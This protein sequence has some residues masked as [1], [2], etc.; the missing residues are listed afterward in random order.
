MN[1]AF[2]IFPVLG[3]IILA[4]LL[5]QRTRY[6]IAKLGIIPLNVNPAFLSFD[7]FDK[8]GNALIITSF[9][10]V[11]F[12]LPGPGGPPIPVPVP[13]APDLVAKLSVNANQ[14][15]NPS[16]FTS[17]VPAPIQI[18]SDKDPQAP[19]GPPQTVW[20]NEAIIAPDGVFPFEALVVAQGFLNT[21]FP[22][23][24]SA[25]RIPDLEEYII[26]QSV[27][28][29]EESRFYHNTAYYDMDGDGLL[30]IISVR[31]GFRVFPQP[32]PPPSGELVWFK[33]P[34]KSLNK[35]VEWE[36]SILVPNLGPDIEITKYDFDDDGIPEFLTT[37]FF[38]GEK[39]TIYGVSGGMDWP[40]LVKGKAAIRSVDVSTDQGKPFGFKVVDLDGD[41]KKDILATNHQEDNC[42]FPASVPGRVYALVPPKE[43][44][45][46]YDSSK[47]TTRVLLDNIYP[48][49]SPPGSRA[50]RLAPGKALPFYP[51]KKEELAGGRPW[52]V[53][54]GDEAAKVWVFRPR[55]RKGWSYDIKIIFDINDSYGPD[56]TQTD[57]PDKPLITISTIGTVAVRYDR[58]GEDGMTEIYVPVF[59][60]QDIFVF[61]F[62]NENGRGGDLDL[63][64][65]TLECPPAIPPGGP[66]QGGPPQGGPPQ[67]GPPQ[68]GPPQG[69]PRGQDVMPRPSWRSACDWPT[70]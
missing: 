48:Q 47:W 24:L 37:H 65:I 2:G 13:L 38:T 56:T 41:G 4:I 8:D 69:G 39:I 68:G 23:R 6:S 44:D 45:M 30:D 5:N 1:F 67:G 17:G 12:Q 61:S 22:G 52:I 27:G 57:L 51:S 63:E 62:R 58:E 36:E 35:N 21:P 9:F 14:S 28:L 43:S 33:N 3:S 50:S 31:S 49:P 60:G 46:I 34:G 55:G 15:F 70:E 53:V 7:E 40:D 16:D 54:G 11:K 26:D 19:P 29:G 64:D 18:L 66:P 32:A 20:P 10:N 25:I 59:E 42:A